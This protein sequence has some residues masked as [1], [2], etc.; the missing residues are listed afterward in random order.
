[1]HFHCY[2]LDFVIIQNSSSISKI[3]N[4]DTPQLLYSLL[5]LVRNCLNSFD[6][7]YNFLLISVLPSL[8][9]LSFLHS[10]VCYFDRSHQFS[11]FPSPLSFHHTF[12]SESYYL[13]IAERHFR[14]SSRAECCHYVFMVT[15]IHST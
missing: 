9:S 1:M 3:K 12:S 4:S 13:T 10:M 11:Q 2:S 8:P 5:F 7:P 6:H 14:K 15:I